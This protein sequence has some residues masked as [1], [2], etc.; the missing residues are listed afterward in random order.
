M[1]TTVEI[2]T[3]KPTKKGT[4]KSSKKTTPEESVQPVVT[5][6][7]VV[8]NTPVVTTPVVETVTTT[9]NL[10]TENL[11]SE[12]SSSEILEKFNTVSD[13][14]FDLVR[15]LKTTSSFSEKDFR[16][17]YETSYKK[18]LK[19]FTQLNM[20]YTESLSKQLTVTQKEVTGRSSTKKSSDK[21]KAAV[22]KNLPVEDIILDFMGLPHG[23]QIS[24]A[25]ALQAITAYVRQVKE[26][27][28]FDIKVPENNKAFK[29]VG[30]LKTL[31]AG[32]EKIMKTRGELTGD[33][34]IPEQIAYIQIMGYMSYCF[35][36][37]ET[38]VV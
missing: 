4:G 29:I 12:T 1:S 33:Q 32:I 38:T 25:S 20:A 22:N 24:R 2:S 14:V 37:P 5:E 30:K 10:V 35:K 15:D 36:K 13:S 28:E 6:T 9:E 16:T 23:T 7:P 8:L 34:K 11:V 31:F 3:A 19:A 27:G 18:F 17:K 26:S 21:Q